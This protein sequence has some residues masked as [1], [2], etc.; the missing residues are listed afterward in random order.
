MNGEVDSQLL[1]RIF[2]GATKKTGINFIAELVGEKQVKYHDVTR[3]RHNLDFDC[4][5]FGK[6]LSQ[7]ALVHAVQVTLYFKVRVGIS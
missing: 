6:R 7:E 4:G 3:S 5:T 2:L 1:N